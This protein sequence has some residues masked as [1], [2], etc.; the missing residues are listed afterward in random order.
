MTDVA[1]GLLRIGVEAI[2]NFKFAILI[3]N[4]YIDYKNVRGYRRQYPC[5][6]L[7]QYLHDGHIDHKVSAAS[8]LGHEHESAILT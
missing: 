6:N 8:K 2:S 7:V 1:I 3:K 5:Y 4:R